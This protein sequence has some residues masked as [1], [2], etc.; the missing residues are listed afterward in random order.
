VVLFFPSLCEAGI[1]RKAVIRSACG[2]LILFQLPS[3][4]SSFIY[5]L[6]AIGNR[7]RA[8]RN[9]GW[10]KGNHLGPKGTGVGQREPLS[11]PKG[12]APS[13]PKKVEIFQRIFVRG[14]SFMDGGRKRL[15]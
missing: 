4:F 14:Y 8:K 7:G 9:R 15:P 6:G 2:N 3:I 1:R 11:G 13:K 5:L 12:T 10:A